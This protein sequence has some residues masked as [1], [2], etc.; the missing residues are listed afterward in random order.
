VPV[1]EYVCEPCNVVWEDT[2]DYE[3]RDD[4]QNCPQCDAVHSY[5]RP[6]APAVLRA[7]Y[8]DGYSR[9][10]GYEEMK[11]IAKLKVARANLRHSERDSVNQEIRERTGIMNKAKDKVTK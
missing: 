7:S 11:R 6:P 4:P 5:R 2:V 8:H 9:G 3:K 10:P 1:Y